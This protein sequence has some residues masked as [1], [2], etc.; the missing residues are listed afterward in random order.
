MIISEFIIQK[1]FKTSHVA[2]YAL[3]SDKQNKSCLIK[4]AEA[5]LSS[6]YAVAELKLEYQLIQKLDSPWILPTKALLQEQLQTAI[7]Y[8]PTEGQFLSDFIHDGK[9]SFSDKIHISILLTEAIRYLHKN[10]LLHRNICP[11]SFWISDDNQRLY[12]AD[13]SLATKLKHDGNSVRNSQLISNIAY[14]SPELTGRSNLS[15][16]NRSDLYSLGATLYELFSGQQ[17]FSDSDQEPLSLMYNQLTKKVIPLNEINSTIPDVI[18]HIVANLLEKSPDQRYQSSLGLLNDLKRVSDQWLSNQKVEKFAIASQ[19]FPEN[20]HISQ[21][22]YGREK[23]IENLLAQFSRTTRGTSELVLIGGYSGVG[24]SALVKELQTPITK[25]KGLYTFGKCDQFNREEPYTVFVQALRLVMRQLLSLDIIAK[26]TWQQ[27][28]RQ[29]LGENASVINEIIPELSLLYLET[30]GPP[31]KLALLESKNRFQ[32]TFSNFVHTLARPEAPLV[33]FL[34]DLQWADRSS[35]MLIEQLLNRQ[36]YLMIIGAYRD[37][38][39]D[40][41][42]PL[43]TMILRIMQTNNSLSQLT[44]TPLSQ[45]S[46]QQMISDS[47]SLKVADVMPLAKLCMEKTQGNPFF[48]NQFLLMLN[49]EEQIY[50]DYDMGQWQ[51]HIDK[52][53]LMAAT[54]NVV[55]LVLKKLTKLPKDT[56]EVAKYAANLSNQFSLKQLAIL[57]QQNIQQVFQH[58]L[59]LIEQGLILPLDENY[60]FET[61]EAQLA[62]A[63]FSFLHDRVQ[64]AAYQLIDPEGL[65]QFKWQ[66]GLRLLAATPAED[67]EKHLFII[68]EQLNGGIEFAKKKFAT[69][70]IQTLIELNIQAAEKAKLSSA[71]SLAQSLLLKAKQLSHNIIS[72]NGRSADSQRLEIYNALAEVS[73]MT[74]DFEQAEA[75]YPLALDIAKTTLEQISVYSVQTAQYQIQGR[76]N[77]AIQ[78]QKKGLAALK[79]IV[80]DDDQ[81]INDQFMAGFE[82]IDNLI[83]GHGISELIHHRE[84]TNPEHNAAMQLLWGMWYASYLGGQIPLNI[85]SIN[86]M[87]EMSLVHGHNDISAFAYVNYALAIIAVFGR[88]E[89]GNEYGHLAITL[90]DKR[91]NVTIQASVYFLYATFTHHWNEPLQ[92][93]LPYFNNSF[94]WALQA[95]DLATVG[96]ICAVRASDTLA[97]GTELNKTH[98]NLLQEIELLK[99]HKQQDMSD[100]VTV[101]ALQSIKGLLGL[102]QQIH[103]FNDDQFSEKGFLSDYSEAPLHLAYFYNAKIRH[104]YLT[105]DNKENQLALLDQTKTV[106]TFVPGQN[107]I[108][109]SSFYSALIML[110]HAVNSDDPLYKQAQEYAE[111]FTVWSNICE[112]NF[113]HK[114]LL[115]KAESA[116]VQGDHATAINYYTEAIEQTKK[117]Q[118]DNVLAVANECFAYFWLEQDKHQIAKSFILSAYDAYANWGAA[119]K[120]RQ[121]QAQWP[122]VSFSQFK[123]QAG[124]N[125]SDQI[126]LQTMQKLNKIITSEIQ[127][128]SLL[129]KLMRILLQNA[130]ADW[131]ALIRVNNGDLWLEALGDRNQ[132]DVLLNQ[133]LQSDAIQ[134]QLPTSIIRYVQDTRVLQVLNNPIKLT[135]FTHDLYFKHKAP[136]SVVGIPVIHQSHLIAIV[137]LENQLIENAFSE[138]HLS[139]LNAIA[140]QAAVS[141]SHAFLYESLEKRVFQRT[142]EL[143]AEKVKAEEA[144]VA[145]SNFLANMSHEI[146]SPMHA[147]IGFT[148]LALR[149]QLTEKQEEY[150]NKTLSASN[151]LLSLIN[152]VLDYSKIEAD[153][154]TLEKIDFYLEDVFQKV[155]D[156]CSHSAHNKGLELFIDIAKNVQLNLVGDPMRLQQVLVNLIS[157]AIKF[158]DNGKI[159]VKV[160]LLKIKQQE[161][162][163]QFSVIDDGIGMTLQQQTRLFDS[164]YQVDESVTRKY[165]GTGLGL[166]ISKQLT[167]LMGGKIHVESEKGIG[168]SFI[169]TAQFA[170]PEEQFNHSDSPDLIVSGNHHIIK[171]HEKFNKLNIPNL[172]QFRILVVDDNHINLQVAIEFLSDT[173]ISIDTAMN[174]SE[175]V[176]QVQENKFDLVL[177]DIQMP[178]MDGLTATKNIR[179][180]LR[181]EQLPIIAM[182]AHA[183]KYDED[184]SINAG[185]NSHITKPIEPELLYRTLCNYL[186]SDQLRQVTSDDE[187][188]EQKIID[189]LS[190]IKQIELTQSIVRLQGK[191]PLY[192]TLINDFWHR[193]Q[194]TSQEIEQCYMAKNWDKLASIT[195]NL[196][197]TAQYIGAKDIAKFSI[198]ID[199]MLKQK[200]RT[201]NI[202]ITSLLTHLDELMSQLNLVYQIKTFQTDITTID[203]DTLSLLII[204]LR[205]LSLSADPEA[206]TATQHLYEMTKNTGYSSLVEKIH[207]FIREKKF[208]TALLEIRNLELRVLKDKGLTTA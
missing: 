62:R 73:Y 23:E 51:W 19:D 207:L 149:T 2:H 45:T 166:A 164:F 88:Y 33:I 131:G 114:L 20:F 184:A 80:P 103:S 61:D 98:E 179:K 79:I 26:E 34:D 71:Y 87:T 122:S 183:T 36:S 9:A 18:S 43:S 177:M 15:V 53:E 172:N 37:N 59:P 124:Q 158:T 186:N 125:L 27:R 143:A 41:T 189:S 39:V 13:L 148:R 139:L 136:L 192:L 3:T 76:F 159:I 204:G 121:L 111:Q 190:A 60:R 134:E 132:T 47:L 24:K 180:F 169:F 117:Y 96:Y 57:T 144:T 197:S 90:A 137:Y 141:L 12:I 161:T 54:S 198:R 157:N 145:K 107:K 92:Q 28:F 82:R 6:Q 163:L 165:G 14:V 38:E 78:I 63:Y 5:G 118:Y 74:G 196:K 191:T 70:K 35:L 56:L 174:G 69:D 25:L 50:Y 85:L 1:E 21:K 42:H 194:T 105:H 193:N 142:E 86:I 140:S 11:E 110:K 199:D 156:I 32:I 146:R 120:T 119:G 152:S 100:C 17:I 104:A 200:N 83:M 130:G 150:L 167:E 94:D 55:E 185:M 147:V 138:E 4:Y 108:P 40:D 31:E 10:K 182:T 97:R 160:E 195:H 81:A 112:A 48:V 135:E 127:L 7:V 175:A 116:R 65:A 106:V 171:Q 99:K 72:T 188:N 176:D 126:D 29:E 115:I 91:D 113:G 187:K 203:L 30:I 102:T 58:L 155:T 22:L 84:M 16:D 44:L 128:N 95:G 68:V 178:I 205:S 67:L 8:R 52:I 123:I 133:S 173:N 64:Q 46:I 75:L 162:E 154:L 153:S 49:E 170:L 66:T 201:L 168:S 109:E 93:S 208:E 206:E 89:Q 101:G 181:P 202:P 77:E 129:E 151:S